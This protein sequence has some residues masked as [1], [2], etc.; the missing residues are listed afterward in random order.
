VVVNS[1]DYQGN[2][3]YE[4]EDKQ[5]YRIS[6]P[7]KIYEKKPFKYINI[8]SKIF[9][10]VFYSW[11]HIRK[12]IDQYDLLHTFGNSWTIG[13]LSWYFAKNNKPIIRELCNDMSNPLYPIQIQRFMKNIF[14]KENT[15]VVAISKRLEI[16]AK[17]FD[18]KNVWMRPNPIDE[19]RFFVD[20]KKKFKLR[21]ELTKFNEDDVVLSCLANFIIRKN[22]IFLLEVLSFLPE[23][24]KMVLAGPLKDEGKEY[25]RQIQNKIEKLNLQSRVDLKV[26]FNDNFDEYLKCSDVF[27]FPSL[28]EGLGTPVLESQACGVPV[29]SNHLKDITDTVIKNGKGGYYLGMDVLNWV[30][31]IKK[32]QSIKREVLVEN[33][34]YI[35]KI[36][37]SSLIDNEY[38]KKIQSLINLN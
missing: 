15:L 10:E 2:Q 13:F 34:K 9:W 29:V 14:Q 27:L 12:N 20:Y 24:Y 23:K 36:S 11:R 3:I 21:N 6:P 4:Y 17:K 22:H 26:G 5:I 25:F 30:E 35:Y 18:M 31:A 19:N 28:S 1:I 7:F 16:L 8:L 37:S 38:H 33:A 32:A